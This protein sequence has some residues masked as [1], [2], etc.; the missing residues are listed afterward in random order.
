MN[1]VLARWN[2]LDP[3]AAAR[4]A[5]PLLRFVGLGDRTGHEAANSG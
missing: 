3:A 1:K 4:E 2:S 5:L